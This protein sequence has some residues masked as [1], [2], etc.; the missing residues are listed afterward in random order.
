[1]N[2]LFVPAALLILAASSIP[3]FAQKPIGKCMR[4]DCAAMQAYC[5]ESRSAG[6][7]PVHSAA[8]PKNGWGPRPTAKSGL[9]LS[10]HC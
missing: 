7:L 10:D 5:E 3:S 8:N 2:R 6:P 9:A 4:S 1:M